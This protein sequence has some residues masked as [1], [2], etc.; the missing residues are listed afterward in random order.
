MG[1]LEGLFENPKIEEFFVDFLQLL[2]AF[3]VVR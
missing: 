1:I 3:L 2:V